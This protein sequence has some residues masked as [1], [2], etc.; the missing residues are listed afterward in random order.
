M[1]SEFFRE[2]ENEAYFRQVRIF[3][4]G[5]GWPNGQDLGPDTIAAE[6]VGSGTA[7]HA[8]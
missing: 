7:D 5:I 2:L 6:L 4:L 8:A 3:V 1:T